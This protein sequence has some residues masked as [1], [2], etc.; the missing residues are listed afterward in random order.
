EHF[1]KDHPRRAELIA[2]LS[3]E[4]EAIAQYQ[5]A[6]S[7]VWWDIIDLG[8]REKNY[9]ESSASAMFVYALAR[10]VREGW[11]PE[12]YMRSATRGW[13]GIQREFI[14]TNAAG[15]TEWEGTVSVS[16]LGG[17]PYRDGSFD[18]YM[19]EKLRTNDP[20]GLGPAVLAAGEMES[21]EKRQRRR[22][23][24]TLP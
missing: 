16:G 22:G 10:G 5:D 17:N 15:E 18:Y 2:I 23:K 9:H 1:P 11:L 24:N 13:Q 3:R 4:A 12:K 20:K 19:S 14:R 8:G 7:G 6:K 21:A